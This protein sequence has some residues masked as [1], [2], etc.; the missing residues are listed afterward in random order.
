MSLIGLAMWEHFTFFLIKGALTNLSRAHVRA[1]YCTRVK[2][3]AR[4]AREKIEPIVFATF[5][6][7]LNICIAFLISLNTDSWFLTAKLH[8]L[9]L[10][11]KMKP[12]L[13]GVYIIFGG[14]SP[15]CSQAYFHHALIK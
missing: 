9:C 7:C 10:Y 8:W 2:E 3:S 11:L 5:G 1:L 13:D 14:V 4:W 6:V 12:F 15:V